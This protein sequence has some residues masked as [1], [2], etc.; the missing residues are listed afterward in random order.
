MR[1]LLP[2]AAFTL[3][4]SLTACSPA[5][6]DAEDGA[7][8]PAISDDGKADGVPM[9]D[10][11]M[12]G[13]LKVANT[14]DK[15]GLRNE[16]HTSSRVATNITKHRAGADTKL[17]T[18]DDDNF[19]TL[20]ELDAVPYV[21]SNVF[22]ALLDYARAKGYVHEDT[23]GNACAAGQTGKTP[24]G[25]STYVCTS[26]HAAAPFVRPP[27]DQPSAS[28]SGTY[29]VGI[30]SMGTG[31]VMAYDRTGKDWALVDSH[32]AELDL[33]QPM[34][35]LEAPN[36]LQAIFKVTGKKTVLHDGVFGDTDALAVTTLEPAIW[37]PGKVLDDHF[38]GAWEA[39]VTLYK[40]NGHWDPDHT[41][42]VRFLITKSTSNDAFMKTFGGAEGQLLSGVIDNWSGSAKSSTGSCL[43]PLAGMG[44]TNPFYGAST[45]AF[46]MFRH[47][48]MHG[49]NDQVIVFTYPS[50]FDGSINGMGNMDAFTPSALLQVHPSAGFLGPESILGHGTPNG[51][52]I[53]NLHKVSSTATSTPC[54]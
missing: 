49:L 6:S 22:A 45:P 24:A 23:G 2:L 3:A 31:K 53:K 32:G 13:I 36:N 30:V 35:G 34:A 52:D 46:S 29:Y 17:G 38:L 14:L 42:P 21:G 44:A 8:D 50:G 26:L 40:G 27:A 28:G 25:K 11:E 12:A 48:N 51:H 19:D 47:P 33:D 4:C 37:L 39:D 43:H 18:A 1:H 20:T 10:A 15:T 5:A 54:E 41:T 16:V 9:T 7:D